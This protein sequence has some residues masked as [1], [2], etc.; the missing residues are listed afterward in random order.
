MIVQ[1][2]SI[3]NI[4]TESLSAFNKDLES[5]NYDGLLTSIY[6][7]TSGEF[8]ESV[9]TRLVSPLK[10]IIVND[11]C[12]WLDLQTRTSLRNTYELLTESQVT[13]ELCKSLVSISKDDLLKLLQVAESQAN[14]VRAIEVQL[15]QNIDLQLDRTTPRVYLNSLQYGSN[16]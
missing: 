6:K 14:K 4:N 10:E 15:R 8:K 7:A 5:G 9:I 13:I 2:E 11:K 1:G 3:I 16:S 12:L